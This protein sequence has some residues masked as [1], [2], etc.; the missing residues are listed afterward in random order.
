MAD[1]T[2]ADAH[3]GRR[4]REVRTWRGL[5]LAELAGLAGF[6]TSYL[7]LIERGER[8]VDR[9]S[10]LE[11]F[12][13]AL[14]VA[15]SE[16][17]GGPFLV[18]G[19]QAEHAAVASLREML[20]EYEFGEPIDVE[21][22]PD[23]ADVQRRL[24]RVEQLRPTGAYTTLGEMLPSLVRD[25]HV[26][27][28]GPHHRAAVE[29]LVHTYMAAQFALAFVNARDL[30]QVAARH[31]QEA[32]NRLSGPEWTGLA[33][34]SRAQ[35]IGSFARDRAYAVAMGAADD[36]ASEIDCPQVADVYG[37]LHLVAAL[38]ATTQGRL[39]QSRD[40]V[41]EAADIAVRPGVG[42]GFGALSFG[43]GNV[44]IWRTMLAVEAGNGGEAVEIARKVDPAT[45]PESVVR[46]AV[47]WIDIGR[48]Y[49]TQRGKAAEVVAAFRRAEDLAPQHTRT[50]PWVR[51]TVNA[52]I[53]RSRRDAGGRELRGLAHRIGLGI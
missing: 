26:S 41:T 49:A 9:R 8:P 48:G 14:R 3:I 33:A 6:S 46:R 34:W 37:M 20:S 32:T 53:A 12:A 28:D 30:A 19:Q 17:T 40:H 21:R 11:A 35:A 42:T 29:G 36:I 5:S 50:S 1:T 44:D 18:V 16:L 47:W 39:D 2:D 52:L 22:T 15:P 31:V 43:R 27:L 25:L 51:E 7:S 13:R 38:A 45:L 24:D 23:W 4:I 10:T